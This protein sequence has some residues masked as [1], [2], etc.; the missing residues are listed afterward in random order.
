MKYK[1]LTHQTGILSEKLKKGMGFKSTAK[2]FNLIQKSYIIC[3]NSDFKRLRL[4]LP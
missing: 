2:C 4:L 3:C 1:R